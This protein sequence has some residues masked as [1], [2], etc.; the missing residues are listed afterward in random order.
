ME[1]KEAIEILKD[2]QA[3]T[4]VVSNTP[5]K[6]NEAIDA[7]IESL[8]PKENT[9]SSRY[10]NKFYKCKNNQHGYPLYIYIKKLGLDDFF[11]IISIS[12]NSILVDYYMALNKIEDYV[13]CSESEYMEALSKFKFKVKGL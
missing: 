9:L 10:E 4:G 5:H 7:I 2:F 8:K 13:E 1:L 3:W 12:D 11:K 6:L